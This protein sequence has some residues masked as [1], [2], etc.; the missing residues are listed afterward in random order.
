M[1]DTRSLARAEALVELRRYAEAESLLGHVLAA[2]PD[3]HRAWCVLALVH[4]GLGQA[5]RMLEAANRAV[6]LAPEEEWG[7]RLASIALARLRQ[8]EEAVRA[9]GEA[10][11]LDPN[12]WRTHVQYS[13]VAAQV[14]RLAQDA[15]RA[16]QRAT[17]L[18][19]HSSDAHFALGLT[20]DATGRHEEVAEHYRQALRL[21]P[22]HV[23]ALNNVTNLER[24]TRLGSKAAGY[25]RA[26]RAD[27]SAAVPRENL[28]LMAGQFLL[29]LTGIAAVAL[30]ACG[31]GRR[32]GPAA[33]VLRGPSDG[34]G[35][36]GGGGRRLRHQGAA[37]RA[38]G[39]AA[40]PA[41]PGGPR[42]GPPG[43]A[44]AHARV[45]G[46]RR[47]RRRRPVGRRGG[48]RRAPSPRPAGDL[49]R[50][51]P[52]RPSPRLTPAFS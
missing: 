15:Y 9:A 19:P 6:A 47:S 2:R 1:D 20:S 18:A 49:G 28:E 41:V 21:D 7:H 13:L 51:R 32:G 27:P 43:D 50:G 31:G 12:G 22:E 24:G 33:R 10:V 4:D 34:R 5:A 46:R 42:R 29:H 39:S 40:L 25:A 52:V 45:P 36:A 16:A 37:G 30:V 26:L 48:C 3:D 8:L 23:N 14:P 44:A 17:E 35:A 38:G 11:R